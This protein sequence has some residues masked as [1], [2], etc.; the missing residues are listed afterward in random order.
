MT[1]RAGGAARLAALAALCVLTPALGTAPASGQTPGQTQPNAAPAP[2]AAPPAELTQP[3]AAPRPPLGPAPARSPAAAAA[4]GQ[5]GGGQAPAQGANADSNALFGLG[6]DASNGAPVNVEAEQGIEWLQ[7]KQE[8]VARGNAKAVRGDVTVYGQTLT[9]YYRKTPSGGSDIWR[10]DADDDV[11]ITTPTDTAVG[12]KGVYDVDNA[13]FVLTGKKLELDTPK[14]VITARDSLEYYK[15]KLYAVARGNAKAVRQDKTVTS[16]IMEAHF[17][18]DEKGQLAM[19]FIE[20]FNNVTVTTASSVA[21]AIYGNYNLDTGIADL[22]GSVKITRGS[23]QLDGE[24]AT[25]NMNSGI[26]RLYACGKEKQVR[27]LLVP[28]QGEAT[29]LPSAGGVAPGAKPAAG[30]EHK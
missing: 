26:S 3:P 7:E 22:K 16:D 15:L 29:G 12:D 30:S 20:A 10:L 23:D 27:G 2:P 9:A 21:H 18:P 28:R 6:G 14:G 8:Y 13:V 25:M 4:K 24:C 19:S 5:A 1:G 11:K 17:K